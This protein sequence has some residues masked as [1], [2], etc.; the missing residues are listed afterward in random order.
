MRLL[1]LGADRRGKWIVLAAWVVA[2]VV[3]APGALRFEEVQRDDPETFLPRDS[4]SVEVIRERRDAAKRDETGVTIVYRRVD[5][6]PL[7]GRQNEFVGLLRDIETSLGVGQR[8]GAVSSAT[9]SDDG[10]TFV[11]T[12]DGFAPAG[13][14]AIVELVGDV[15]AIVDASA[16][17]DLR[18]S[19]TGA[20]G[21]TADTEEVFGAVNSRLLAATAGLVF[22]LL[23]LTYRSPVF[24]ILPMIAVFAAEFATRAG[25][26]GLAEAGLAVNGQSAGILLVLVFGAGTDYA[27][28]LTSRYREE[29]RQHADH[30]RAM[31]VALER[32]TPAILAS[33]ATNIAALLVLS[34][35][36]V[37]G[38]AGLGRIAALGIAVT[39]LTMLTLLPALLTIAG[40]RVFWP[41][42]PRVGERAPGPGPFGRIAAFI[43]P[44]PRAVWIG[45][46]IV[47]AVIATGIVRLDNDLAGPDDFRAPVESVEGLEDLQAAFPPGWAGPADVLM[48]D[49][50]SFSPVADA[51]RASP[52]IES[53]VTPPATSPLPLVT[54]RPASDPF[55]RET[56]ESVP[57]LRR[58]AGDAAL[59]EG[60]AL[61]GGAS[62]EEY[63]FR[64][65]MTR[66][67]LVVFPLVLLVVFLILVALLRSLAMPAL[68]L[69]S[70]VLS[71]AAALGGG[72]LIFEALGM[73]AES[74][75]LPLFAFVFLVALGVDYNI[76]LLVRAREESREHGAVE[77]MLRA[78]GT[79]GGVITAAGLVLAGT[80]GALMVL[81]LTSLIQIG[82]VIG[83]GILLDTFVVRT[84]VIPALVAD[85]GAPAWWP[86]RLGTDHR[87]VSTPGPGELGSDG[88]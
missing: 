21:F 86:L 61:V 72:A 69:T 50:G 74:P 6:G 25:G 82:V 28:F 29:L 51:L 11:A 64:R 34:V 71:W 19:V 87:G 84:L 39:L 68:A 36:V 2:L 48:T 55:S 22:L 30:H 1:R 67:Q 49:P 32:T 31:A 38:T 4:E 88:R 76:F 58:I 5:G 15:R 62:A 46:V 79:T 47:L 60:G 70:V 44:R 35:A 59:I 65:A 16:A 53:V 13:S 52:L 43:R 10:T 80:F 9:L 27:L 33:A 75:A 24:W 17:E 63:D 8:I 12:F 26:T 83:L 41:L 57:E 20:A 78:L 40:R 14:D 85:L 3:I 42:V 56:W 45:G 81:P 23:I 7:D 66:D 18:V 37:E 54:A 73:S 77:G